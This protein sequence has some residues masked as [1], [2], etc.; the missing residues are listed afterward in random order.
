MTLQLRDYQSDAINEL[1]MGIARGMQSQLLMASTGSGK[2]AVSASIKQR[3]FYKDK[4]SLFVVDSL[5]L[6]DQAV[7]TFEKFGLPVGVIQGLHPKTDYS[8]PI[9]VAT[10]QTLKSRWG[11]IPEALKFDLVVID[12]CHVLH[13]AHI[14]LMKECKEKGVP[15]IGLSATPFRDNL[16]EHFERM[17]LATTTADLIAKGYLSSYKAYAP[18]TPDLKSI[19]TKSNGDYNEDAL[20]EFMGD[21]KIVG[22]IITHWF[23]LGENRQT[24]VFAANVAHS[25]LIID[26]FVSAGVNAA[27][28]DGYTDIKERQ[29]I[30]KQYREGKIKILSSVAVLTKGF[31]APETSC[32]VIA[33]PTKSL[34]LHIQMLGRGLRTAK[35]KDNCIFIDHAGN[36]IRNGFPDDD[37]PDTL[38]TGK[39]KNNLDRKKKE[40]KERVAKP[41]AKCHTL[42]TLHTCP[43][44]GFTPE[45][46]QDVEVKDGHLYEIGHDTIKAVKMNKAQKAEF[47]AELLGYAKLKGYKDG[48]V[49]HKC[50]EYV[51]STPKYTNGIAAKAPSAKTSGIIKHLEIK[52]R[53]R[54]VAQQNGAQA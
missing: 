33:R 30:I 52:A 47:Y 25:K 41:C 5:E 35:G 1:R 54:W 6:V 19:R 26:Q 13:K 49:Y 16:G 46:R 28:I 17:V 27:H 32:V 7:E 38:H 43:Q 9:Q 51:G 42:S 45:H 24:I 50:I 36:M 2:T 14:D 15:V 31:D 8:K 34:M 12:E 22:D 39:E 23:K 4:R 18:Y 21:S 11:S 20:A 10:I 37:L 48:W 3:A 29:Q 44:C 53:K 40:K